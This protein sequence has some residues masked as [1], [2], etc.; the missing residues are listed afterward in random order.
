M[1]DDCVGVGSVS[2]RTLTH[3]AVLIAMLTAVI[4]IRF[5]K[6][7]TN[8]EFMPLGCWSQIL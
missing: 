8:N 7:P 3:S 6:F 2:V 5:M 4:I 1:I